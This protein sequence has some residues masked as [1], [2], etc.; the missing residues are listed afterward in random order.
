VST[1]ADEGSGGSNAAGNE[2]LVA[3]SEL[4]AD[5]T[6]YQDADAA[7]L[8]ATA[9]QGM[10]VQPSEEL[11]DGES[12]WNDENVEDMENAT[13]AQH[14]VS[15]GSQL[16][17]LEPTAVPH[18]RIICALSSRSVVLMRTSCKFKLFLCCSCCIGCMD[19]Y[20]FCVVADLQRSLHVLTWRWL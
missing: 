13:P 2:S 15:S 14:R 1:D 18:V 5:P 16:Q 3:P 17:P 6:V 10:H 9:T 20:V 8:Q 19:G 4:L 12:E 11:E 7:D